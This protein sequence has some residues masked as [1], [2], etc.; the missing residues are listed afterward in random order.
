MNDF[1]HGHARQIDEVRVRQQVQLLHQQLP[2]LLVQRHV[3][4]IRQR[5]AGRAAGPKLFKNQREQR[6]LAGEMVVDR[7]LGD[8]SRGGDAVHAGGIKP[9]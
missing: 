9:G 6:F 4:P 2:Q 3:G 1:G 7:A 8:P 5:N